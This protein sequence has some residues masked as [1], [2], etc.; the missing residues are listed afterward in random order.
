MK[1]AN[2]CI[3]GIKAIRIYRLN[4]RTEKL[5]RTLADFGSLLE[6]DCQIDAAQ[7]YF[8]EALDVLDS[9]RGDIMLHTEVL[10][11]TAS[12]SYVRKDYKSAARHFEKLITFAKRIDGNQNNLGIFLYWFGCASYFLGRHEASQKSLQAAIKHFKKDNGEQKNMVMVILTRLAEGRNHIKAD[13]VG[14]AEWCV[15]EAMRLIKP[16]TKSFTED[17]L[18]KVYLLSGEIFRALGN[19]ERSIES[20]KKALKVGGKRRGIQKQRHFLDAQLQIIELYL[21]VGEY[22]I[23]RE[24]AFK[25][26]DKMAYQLQGNTSKMSLIHGL[27][28]DIE[29]ELGE[30]ETAIIHYEKAIALRDEPTIDSCE[31]ILKLAKCRRIKN[32]WEGSLQNLVQAEEAASF[33]RSSESFLTRVRLERAN[34]FFKQ[35][36]IDATLAIYASTIGNFHHPDLDCLTRLE[37]SPIELVDIYTQIG[38]SLVDQTKLSLEYFENAV[39]IC[40]LDQIE[41]KMLSK[42]AWPHLIKAHEVL[43]EQCRAQV[44]LVGDSTELSF[45]Q[46][47]LGNTL[48]CAKEFQ[49][50]IIIFEDFLEHQRHANDRLQLSTTL[51]NIGSCY[52][53]LGNMKKAIP[54]LEEALNVGKAVLGHD[55]VDVADTTFTLARACE[56]SS[57]IEA[58]ISYSQETFKIRIDAF[59]MKSSQII[60]TMHAMGMALIAADRVEGAIKIFQDALRIQK[61]LP[62]QINRFLR[63]TT[64]FL[65][66]QAFMS[67]ESPQM[68]LRHLQIFMKS[69]CKRSSGIQ[70]EIATALYQIGSSSFIWHFTHTI[71]IAL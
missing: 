38:S 6:K 50:A 36:K 41:Y 8:M 55:H 15:N 4:G 12:N 30:I 53:E 62:Q 56:I 47:N 11:K 37:L 13:K 18:V 48:I 39:Q 40:S 24:L 70:V 63:N 51:H 43:I 32:H 44:L 67:N 20:T 59:G 31:V 17:E 16:C 45:L 71:I 28:G 9:N 14:E 60:Q 34:V 10:H 26:T 5:A 19:F 54:I 57:D 22:V 3:F 7:K 2:T 69:P 21:E 25:F 64:H 66:A 52:F 65:I 46:K 33:L 35:G 42:Q 23:A 58:S 27:S 61:G 29:R 49:R 68:A 1:P